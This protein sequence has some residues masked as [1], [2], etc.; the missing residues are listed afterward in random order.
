MIDLVPRQIM[1]NGPRTT[2][3][4]EATGL[5]RPPSD[6][7]L[8]HPP[9]NVIFLHVT[10]PFCSAVLMIALWRQ[11][12]NFHKRAANWFLDSRLGS[13]GFQ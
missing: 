1:Q 8:F 4:H 2:H 10:S 5:H 11:V 9:P 12:V 6:A 7:P 13:M 3:K